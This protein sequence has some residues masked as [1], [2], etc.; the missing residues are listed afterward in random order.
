MAHLSKANWVHLD[1]VYL[2]DPNS[3][4][5]STSATRDHRLN[6]ETLSELAKAHWPRLEIMKI[7]TVVVIE[8]IPG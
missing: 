4:I 1:R 7:S 8:A 5:I 2:H 6:L 3:Y